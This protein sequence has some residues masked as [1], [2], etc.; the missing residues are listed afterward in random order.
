MA[1][2]FGVLR[3]PI[4]EIAEKS[5]D[6][7]YGP[8]EPPEMHVAGVTDPTP[9]QVAQVVVV[10]LEFGLPQAQRAHTSPA[11]IVSRHSF[12]SWCS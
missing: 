6:L 5:L 8:V 3:G 10:L 9:A 1:N 12:A 7:V 2:A 4:L 11:C